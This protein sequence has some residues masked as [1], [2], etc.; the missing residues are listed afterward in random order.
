MCILAK[1]RAETWTKKIGW[2]ND[3]VTTV[4]QIYCCFTSPHVQ[5][6]V[7]TFQR[8]WVSINGRS[9]RAGWFI[10]WKLLF[11]NPH[12][13]QE[14]S[15]T[16]EIGPLYSLY[17]N[18]GVSYITMVND[19]PWLRKLPYLPGSASR[20]RRRTRT[21]WMSATWWCI[22]SLGRPRTSQMQAEPRGPMEYR[23]P[24]LRCGFALGI[25]K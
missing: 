16:I 2:P 20:L 10:S 24:W 18:L 9:P 8:S 19:V 11:C 14:T 7:L 3:K 23:W 21:C 4:P 15:R 12:D 25:Y 13:P 17:P 22:P 6:T 5:K 1:S